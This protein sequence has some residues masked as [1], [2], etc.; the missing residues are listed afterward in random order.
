MAV[1][2]GLRYALERLDT[3]LRLLIT[4]RGDSNV[5]GLFQ[6]PIGRSTMNSPS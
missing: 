6:T 4:M 5:E 3:R 2:D 1:Y